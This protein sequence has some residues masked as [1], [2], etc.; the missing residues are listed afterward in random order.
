MTPVYSQGLSSETFWT[1]VEKMM[2][3]VTTFASNGRLWAVEKFIKIIVNFTLN[4]PITGLTLPYHQNYKISAVYLRFVNM[5][6]QMA[7]F[8]AI[9]LNIICTTILA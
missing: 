1:M 8:F 7:S 9:L 6:T 2:I 3:L 5:R 4:R